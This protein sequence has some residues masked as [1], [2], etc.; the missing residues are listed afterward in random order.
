MKP[1]QS[2]SAAMLLA[3]VLVTGPGVAW[4][5]GE[6]ANHTHIGQIT[7]IDRH[8]KTFTIQDAET[9][10]YITFS[11]SDSILKAAATSLRVTVN[12]VK[13]G[14]TLVARSIKL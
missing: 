6:A 4:S 13:Q 1:K 14:D 3:A 2:L 11:A 7:A 10:K 12:F 9:N 8:A 5:C